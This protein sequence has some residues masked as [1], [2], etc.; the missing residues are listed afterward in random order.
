MLYNNLYF[1]FN[2][3]I[4][5]QHQNLLEFARKHVGQFVHGSIGNCLTNGLIDLLSHLCWYLWLIRWD[6]AKFWI[7]LMILLWLFFCFCSCFLFCTFFLNEQ[8]YI[9]MVSGERRNKNNFEII[10]EYDSKIKIPILSFFHS[11]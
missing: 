7:K 1:H 8:F 4:V 2:I 3:M 5:V 10:I 11:E 9:G 6:T